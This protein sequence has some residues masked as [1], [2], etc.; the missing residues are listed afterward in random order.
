LRV[1]STYFFFDFRDPLKQNAINFLS[2]IVAQLC[3]KATELPAEVISAHAKHDEG[4]RKPSLDSLKS[5]FKLFVTGDHLDTIY[6]VADAMDECP[7]FAKRDELLDLLQFFQAIPDS[8][9]H[10]LVTSRPKP[11]IKN[12]LVPLLTAPAISVQG[13]AVKADISTYVK[14][15]LD[16][17]KTLKAWPDEVKE[18][19]EKRLVEG[20]QGM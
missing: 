9:V 4:R 19:V 2:S 17:D 20:A 6:V 8:N 5:I 14:A 16:A 13:L 11:D 18:L 10:V 15:Q 7:G 12:S 3:S 1:A